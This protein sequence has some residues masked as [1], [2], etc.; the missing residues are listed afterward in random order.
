MNN[1]TVIPFRRQRDFSEVLNATFAFLR[2]MLKPLAKYYAFLI[3]P[4]IALESLISGIFGLSLGFM[5]GSGQNTTSAITGMFLYYLAY[6]I[7]TIVVTAYINSFIVLY[8]DHGGANFTINDINR[9][10]KKYFWKLFF[11]MLFI[12]VIIILSLFFFFIPGIFLGIVLSLFGIVLIREQNGV[13]NAFSRCFDLVMGNWWQ[14]FFILAVSSL[15][16]G[17]FNLGLQ[18]PQYAVLFLVKFHSTKAVMG[19][20]YQ[21]LITIMT[22][23]V[24]VA[25]RFLGLIPEIASA[26]QYF[27]LVE[28]KELVGLFERIDR[29]KTSAAGA[30]LN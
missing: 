21:I 6:Y 13:V 1:A 18:L 26:F 28:K 9:L 14:T 8:M 4:F 20:G 2:Q 17:V 30:E 25:T 23:I 22:F 10:I 3:T 16:A 11:G 5:G 24:G 7:T 12:G 27:N 29:I 19:G 15:I